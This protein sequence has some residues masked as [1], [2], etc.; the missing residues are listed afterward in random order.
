MASLRS[1]AWENQA[2]NAPIQSIPKY[3]TFDTRPKVFPVAQQNQLSSVKSL[4]NR[5]GLST[6]L[7]N[8]QVGSLLPI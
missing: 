4:L 1:S 2:V 5:T 3:D 8:D 6:E 7:G